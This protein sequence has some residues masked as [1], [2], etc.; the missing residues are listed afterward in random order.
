MIKRFNTFEQ[1]LQ[2]IKYLEEQHRLGNHGLNK[3]KAQNDKIIELAKSD[4]TLFR[5]LGFGNK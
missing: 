1:I 5:T 4:N 2:A 3:F